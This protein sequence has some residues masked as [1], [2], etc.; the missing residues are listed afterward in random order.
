MPDALENTNLR[1]VDKKKN[2][3]PTHLAAYK[4]LNSK[5]DAV[6]FH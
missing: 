1:M 4:L 5:Q 3:T 2:G 6:P